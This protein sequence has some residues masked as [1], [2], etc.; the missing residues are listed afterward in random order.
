M[1]PALLH[2]L[3]NRYSNYHVIFSEG[4]KCPFF[5]ASESTFAKLNNQNFL[6][7]CCAGS[8]D[9]SNVT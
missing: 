6:H 2:H 7:V 4:L 1:K 5:K 9:L 8:I 3:S